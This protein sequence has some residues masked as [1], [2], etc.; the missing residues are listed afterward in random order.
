MLPH[1]CSK[2]SLLDVKVRLSG[3]A[4][5]SART[6]PSIDGEDPHSVVKR[7]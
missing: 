2:L 1:G 6:N 7:E 4:V 5:K 3:R